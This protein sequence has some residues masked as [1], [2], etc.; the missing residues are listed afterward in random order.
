[1]AYGLIACIAVSRRAGTA[2]L[3]PRDLPAVTILKPLCGAEPETYECLRSFCDQAYPEFQVVFGI[4]D[5]NDPVLGIVSRLKEEFP[6]RDLQIVVDRRQHG[7]SRKVS[8]LINMM[9]LAR[10]EFLVLSDSDVRV[11]R[12]YLARIVAPLLDGGVG[13]VTC[14]YRGG[15]GQGLWSLLGS[16]FINEWFIPSVRVAAMAGSRSFAFGATIAMRRQV[17]ARIGGFASIA[18]QLADDYRLGELTRRLGLRTVLSEVVVDVRVAE[19]SVGDLVLHELRWLRTIRALRPAGYA[20]CFVT[21]GMPVAVVG[22]LLAGGTAPVLGLL[23]A[24]AAAR[25]MLHL[26]VREPGSPGTRLLILP[27]HDLLT[28]SLWAW[29]FAARSVH[30]RE[31]RYHVTRDGSA[32]PVARI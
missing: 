28:A 24:T 8:N 14:A 6:Q 29:S 2:R 7:N 3:A 11:N 22:T 23:A 32:Q 10:H 25:G 27:L 5:S 9:A 20:F 18:D 15:P 1:M 26:S 16:L 4:S 19:R 12:D 21:F 31:D 13:I 17:L 30:W